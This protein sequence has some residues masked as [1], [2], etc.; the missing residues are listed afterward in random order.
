VLL[1]LAG[2]GSAYETV[3]VASYS[4]YQLR[5]LRN[6]DWRWTRLNALAYPEASKRRL[7]L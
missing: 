3:V 2:A 6:D 7:V 5:V 4:Q 1:A